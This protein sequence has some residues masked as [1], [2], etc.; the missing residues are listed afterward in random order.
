MPNTKRYLSTYTGIIKGNIRKIND[1]PGICFTVIFSCNYIFKQF[2][3]SDSVR[4]SEMGKKIS[5]VKMHNLKAAW[6][7]EVRKE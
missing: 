2:T 3:S 6:Q 5:E 1:L 4:K 7:G